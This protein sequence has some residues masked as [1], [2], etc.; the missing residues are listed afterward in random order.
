M[1][2]TLTGETALAAPDV[3]EAIR[4]ELVIDPVRMDAGQLRRAA[5]DLQAYC[6]KPIAELAASELPGWCAEDRRAQAQLGGAAGEEDLTA[7]Y[8]GTLRYVIGNL[9]MEAGHDRLLE[10]RLLSAACRR[11]GVRQALDFGGGAGGLCLHLWSE[12]VACDYMDVPG[13]TLDFASWRFRRHEAPA[14]AFAHDAPLPPGAYDAV[15]ARDVFEH[16]WDVEGA[17]RR[18]AATLR[19]GGRLFSFS[20]F[21]TGGQH[22]HLEKNAVY[23]DFERWNALLEGAG[24]RFEGQLK[25]GRWSR[26][27]RRAGWRNAPTGARLS[28]RRKHGG[29]FLSHVKAQ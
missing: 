11:F 24:L 23:Q 16:L 7:Y 18:I 19:P 4:R 29:N 26:L 27:L 12:R 2:T 9:Y 22:D 15:F 8:A 3:F 25:P 5:D 6:G 13:P 28:P 1:N 10:Y 21:D 17:V 14:R 20:T